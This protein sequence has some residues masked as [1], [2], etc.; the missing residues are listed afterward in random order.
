MR[1]F[2]E[3]GVLFC[4]GGGGDKGAQLSYALLQGGGHNHL[5]I[6]K[7]VGLG[8]TVFPVRPRGYALRVSKCNFSLEWRPREGFS[9]ATN[10]EIVLVQQPA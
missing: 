4:A 10:R 5:R 6:A 9:E 8:C 7:I 1:E 3:G 2:G